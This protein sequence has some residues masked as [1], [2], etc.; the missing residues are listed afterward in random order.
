MC[1]GLKK[2]SPDKIG[3][4]L[5]ICRFPIYGRHVCLKT[6][7]NAVGFCQGGCGCLS[8]ILNYLCNS[9]SVSTIY[10][11][12]TNS[13]VG[14][15]APLRGDFSPYSDRPVNLALIQTQPPITHMPPNAVPGRQTKN[16]C[17]INN[18]FYACV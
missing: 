6:F 10:K 14:L 17:I 18:Y 8:A 2:A 16:C 5:F 12:H 1:E 7:T 13:Y 15:S 9:A 11:A 3:G 4:R